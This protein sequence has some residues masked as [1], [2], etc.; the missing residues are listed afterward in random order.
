MSES[1]ISRHSILIQGVNNELSSAEVIKH[2]KEIFP[3]ISK[4]SGATPKKIAPPL[5]V[6]MVNDFETL[7][8]IKDIIERN[9]FKN[10]YY[11]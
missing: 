5:I 8:P 1:T 3:E 6:Q 9:G 4:L 2:L 11:K 7:M 10:E